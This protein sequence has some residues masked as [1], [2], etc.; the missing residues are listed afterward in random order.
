MCNS[1]YGQVNLIKLDYSRLEKMKAEIKNGN[2]ELNLAYQELIES[3]D[4]IMRI[5]HFPK[6]TEKDVKAITPD[7]HDYVS[8]AT[9]WWPNPNSKD[10]FPYIRKDG[11]IYPGA[12]KINNFKN[13]IDVSERIKIL[14][15]AYY[16]SN[17]DK[18]ASTAT[19]L[20]NVFFIKDETRMNPNLNHAQF[21]Y[22]LNK[23]RVEGIIE[24][25]FFL[26][27]LD[28]VQLMKGSSKFPMTTYNKLQAWFKDFLHWMED[29][30]IGKQGMNLKNNIGTSYQLQRMAY[31][32]FINNDMMVREIYNDNI[33]KLLNDQFKGDGAQP[34]EL[35]R[36]KPDNYSVANLKYWIDVNH[37]LNNANIKLLESETNTLL[38]AYR[39]IDQKYTINKSLLY[40]LQNTSPPSLSSAKSK[41]YRMSKPS[42]T[43]AISLLTNSY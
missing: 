17:D 27:L 5:R 33:K 25:R 43:E 18:Y 4:S 2:V 30:A 42:L 14:G 21:I 28:G 24:S 23:G 32:L 31:Y 12:A 8:M 38:H 9:Y 13:L 22:G 29:S 40:S 39:F 34:L 6:V 10:G 26:G 11:K 37:V 15:L 41:K 19:G 36:D 3:A 20:I 16:F 35:T 7:I 1:L